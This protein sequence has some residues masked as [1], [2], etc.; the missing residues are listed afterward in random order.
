MSDH[1]RRAAEAPKL[2]G[3]PLTE[4]EESG[5]RRDHEVEDDRKFR[6]H[7]CRKA[8]TNSQ[9]LGG[10]QNAHKRERQR[11]R[12]FHGHSDHRRFFTPSKHQPPRLFFPSTPILIPSPYTT[13]STT[14]F[15]FQLQSS[16]SHHV[17]TL[18]QR[19]VGVNVDVHLKLS[20]SD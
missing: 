15:P 16:P 12:R 5:E 14:R 18:P 2:F 20:L 7:Y 19:D 6:C 1:N 4:Q 8:F 9:A 3:F 10:H 11:A 17:A 13:S